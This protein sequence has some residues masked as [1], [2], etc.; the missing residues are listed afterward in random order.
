ML[1]RLPLIFGC[2]Y[3]F[4][5]ILWNPKPI[6][7]DIEYDEDLLSLASTNFIYLTDSVSTKVT[8]SKWNI[9][10]VAGEVACPAVSI[11]TLGYLV[12]NPSHVSI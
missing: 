12:I 6:V 4:V 3:N 7:T 10:N 2:K 9:P 5:P 8:V 1:V 11:V